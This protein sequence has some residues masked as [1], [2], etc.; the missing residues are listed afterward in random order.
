VEQ[1]REQ[2]AG[3]PDGTREWLLQLERRVTE[4]ERAAAQKERTRRRSLFFM[5]LAGVLYVL[6]VYWQMNQSLP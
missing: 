1:E 6:V 3:K 4:L 2:A 5:L